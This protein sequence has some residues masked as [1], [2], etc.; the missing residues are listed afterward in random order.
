[1]KLSELTQK[2][3]GVSPDKLTSEEIHLA[4]K[5]EEEQKRIYKMINQ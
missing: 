1:M 4:E 2:W 3:F 5:W